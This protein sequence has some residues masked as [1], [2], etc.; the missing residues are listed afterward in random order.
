MKLTIFSKQDCTLGE[1]PLWHT[2]R[3]SLF[4]VDIHNQWVYEKKIDSIEPNYDAQWRIPYIVTA[5]FESSDKQN[6]YLL[7]NHSLGKLS[8]NNGH[9]TPLVKLNLNHK[10]R[11]NDAGIA[12]DGSIWF[13]IMQK[14]PTLTIGEVYSISPSGVLKKQ[15]EGIGIP[16]T[17]C[18]SNNGQY[19]YLTDSLTQKMYRYNI[20][21]NQL[22]IDSKMIFIDLS[23]TNAT[24][25]GG[26]MDQSNQLWNAQWGDFNVKSYNAL[27][28]ESMTIELPIIQPSC[29]C[30]GGSQL[31]ILFITSA[32]E[33]LDKNQIKR[34]PYSGFTFMLELPANYGCPINQFDLI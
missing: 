20:N 30:F 32:K 27:G 25:D 12:P 1:G 9:Y 28:Q 6:L 19:F 3:Q 24:P 26:A 4:W 18:W 34:S 14:Q 8:L 5:L 31:N 22:E 11:T 21:K 17:F 15:L 16:N 23:T 7:T 10:F 29:C 2:Q 13:G 33:G